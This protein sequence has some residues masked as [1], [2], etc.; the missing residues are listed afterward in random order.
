[1]TFRTCL[2]WTAASQRVKRDPGCE[3]DVHPAGIRE[4]PL[5]QCP[6][7]EFAASR[8]GCPPVTEGRPLDSPVPTLREIAFEWGRIGVIGFGG[9]P[10]HISLLRGLCV[11]RRG[12]I[13][14]EEFERA[15]AATSMLPGPAST[16]MSIWCAWRLRGTAGALVGGACFIVPGLVLILALAAAFL[17]SSPPDWLRGAGAGAGAAVAAVAVQAGLGLAP[18]VWRRSSPRERRRA[19]AYAV[20]GGAAA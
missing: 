5:Y 20:A 9:P 19:V 17:A 6:R 1:M 12:W 15:I 7:V 3:Q 18:P 4:R 11:E 14:D 2:G 16:Q 10:A 8:V 13:R